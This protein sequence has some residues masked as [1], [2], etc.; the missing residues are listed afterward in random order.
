MNFLSKFESVQSSVGI[1]TLDHVESTNLHPLPR[2][3]WQ[4]TTTTA[5]TIGLPIQQQ[6]P[7]ASRI[8]TLPQAEGLYR[9]GPPRHTSIHAPTSHG[10]LV[11]HTN[12]N[13]TPEAKALPVISHNYQQPIRKDLRSPEKAADVTV[14]YWLPHGPRITSLRNNY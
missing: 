3:Q 6:D 9:A 13:S 2:W 11:N 4:N 1:N 8:G 7:A 10:A 12:T 14:A 5:S